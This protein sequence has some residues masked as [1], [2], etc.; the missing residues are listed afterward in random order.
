M[1]RFVEKYSAS[2]EK[3]FVIHSKD[4]EYTED[5]ACMPI[6]MTCLP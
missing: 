5:A 2:L 1:D 4:M 3:P 6:Y